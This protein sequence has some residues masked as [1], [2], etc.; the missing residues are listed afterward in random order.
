[1]IT[2]REIVATGEIIKERQGLDTI[3]KNNHAV[4]GSDL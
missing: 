2:L 3:I 4:V 1:M